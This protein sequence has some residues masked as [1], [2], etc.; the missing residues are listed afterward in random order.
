MI[1]NGTI[2]EAI[3]QATRLNPNL[4]LNSTATASSGV[5]T[6][7]KR[8]YTNWRAM[9]NCEP[10]GQQWDYASFQEVDD[11]AGMLADGKGENGHGE[12]LSKGKPKMA[13]GP[14]KCGRVS[15]E[16]SSAIYWCN[17][18]STSKLTSS[19]LLFCLE[20]DD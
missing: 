1:L 10:R 6:L 13:P 15:C 16:G 4:K 18:V 12:D 7:S 20:A 2:Q 5:H 9:P 19:Y 3:A 14:G 8:K 11:A 17:D